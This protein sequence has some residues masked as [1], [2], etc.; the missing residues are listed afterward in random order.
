MTWQHTRHVCEEAKA[1]NADLLIVHINTYG[2]TLQHADSI[3]TALLNFPKTTIAFVDNNAASAGALI[4]LAC[5][6]IYMQKGAS[7]GGWLRAILI[8]HGCSHGRA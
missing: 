2:G 6:S 3:R 7:M 1:I 8:R 4:A 5:D